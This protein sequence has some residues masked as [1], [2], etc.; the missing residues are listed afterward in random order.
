MSK[1]PWHGGTRVLEK[2]FDSI[3]S[4]L[5]LALHFFQLSQYISVPAVPIYLCPSCPNIS[6]KIYKHLQFSLFLRTFGNS[7]EHCDYLWNILK[8]LELLWLPINLWNPKSLC[9]FF[10]WISLPFETTHSLWVSVTVHPSV[11]NSSLSSHK[12]ILVRW[13]CLWQTVLTH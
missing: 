1:V 7:L 4:T 2:S 11:Y 5:N 12:W 10:F 8:L 9:A 3:F 13:C 6:L